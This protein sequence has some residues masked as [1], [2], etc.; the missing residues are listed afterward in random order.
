MNVSDY[1]AL[2]TLV[3]WRRL[4]AF[5]VGTCF[6]SMVCPSD[7]VENASARVCAFQDGPV[8]IHMRARFILELLSML[9]LRT[10]LY[11]VE[12]YLPS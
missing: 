7:Q 9:A 3:I 4:L 10:R 5:L 2:R 11:G 1:W 6:R 12:Y 8:K